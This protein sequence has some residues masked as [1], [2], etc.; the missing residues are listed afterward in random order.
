[1]DV[2]P[3]LQARLVQQNRRR[4]SRKSRKLTDRGLEREEERHCACEKHSAVRVF[5]VFSV[6]WC[7][8]VLA[9]AE[10]PKAHA[11]IGLE[12]RAQQPSIGTFQRFPHY[13]KNTYI[14]L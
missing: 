14:S 5:V 1:M 13:R 10:A 3:E 9:R 12:L 6:L 2:C 4:Y 7:S 8:R 11:V